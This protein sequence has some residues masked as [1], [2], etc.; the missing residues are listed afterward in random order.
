MR[1]LDLTLPTPAENLALDEALLN[2]AE[3]DPA[4]E[5]VLRL[6]ESPVPFVCVG[7]ASKLGKEVNLAAC[8]AS[9]VPVL[10]RCSGGTS[11]V[12]GPGCLMYAVVINYTQ[13]PQLRVVDKAHRYVME[14]MADALSTLSNEV[15][16]KGTCDL[17]L[18]D[19]KISGNALRCKRDHFLYH[20]T[21]LYDFP[22]SNI[23]DW[24]GDEPP[25]QPE[26]RDGRPH[27]SFVANF[28]FPVNAIRGAICNQWQITGDLETW[29]EAET[30]QLVES[31]YQLP[32]WHERL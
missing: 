1:L 9:H 2:T 15:R 17:T 5:S 30:K 24:L 13:H 11:V 27:N 20:G 29:P 6:W 22:I 4:Q 12:A 31:R 14:R 21:V 32:S 25:R 19:R 8:Q 7:R 18:G 16:L 10:R 26:Y 23:Q 28:P 3:S